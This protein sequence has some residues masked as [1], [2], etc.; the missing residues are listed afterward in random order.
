MAIGSTWWCMSSGIEDSTGTI[1]LEITQFCEVPDPNHAIRITR[2][3]PGRRVSL[4]PRFQGSFI[5]IGASETFEIMVGNL[6]DLGADRY[7]L[8]ANSNAG[9][10]VLFFDAGMTPISSTE[11]L[12]EGESQ[13]VLV[14]VTAPPGSSMGDEDR[15]EITA[16]SVNDPTKARTGIIDAAIPTPFAQTYRNEDEYSVQ[17]QLIWP[18]GQLDVSI[19]QWEFPYE[20]AV[21]ETPQGNFVHVWQSYEK[22]NEERYGYVLKYA[23]VDQFG[24]VITAV[25]Q[26]STLYTG[27]TGFH[28]TDVSGIALAV[29]PDGNVGVTWVRYILRGSD[30]RLNY[31]V[32]FADISPTGK[33][34]HG[35]ERITQNDA[36]SDYSNGYFYF[37]YPR[38]AASEDNH[39]MLA[40]ARSYSKL[41]PAISQG[42]IMTTIRGSSG[43]AVTGVN[44]ITGV[45]N[46]A[47][48]ASL[49]LTALTDNRFFL[50]HKR[51][52]LEN[53]PVSGNWWI[54]GYDPNFLVYNS[55]GA[56]IVAEQ[57]YSY[58]ADIVDSIQTTSGLLI[59]AISD[60]N[61]YISK[62]SVSFT[63]LDGDDYSL[64]YQP[65]PGLFTHP[66]GVEYDSG[67]LSVTQDQDGNAI[68]TWMDVDK[69]NL[70]YALI[71]PDGKLL[72]SPSIFE[73]GNFMTSQTG[74]A[75]T[76]N[77]STPHIGV[78]LMTEFSS[79]AFSAKPGETAAIKFRF[80]N[81]GMS[82]ATGV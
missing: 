48:F 68:M 29:A 6:G 32:W 27:G 18:V 37:F 8:T 62:D 13:T 14:Q 42:S 45:V 16:T 46:N 30:N 76:T 67:S 82:Q 39:F 52:D 23:V 12:A 63:I 56:P 28:Y 25:T 80:A 53:N 24:E 69:K 43:A 55:V 36:F 2:P 58:N 21:V 66:S 9:W 65:Y 50:T 70:F 44:N 11:E 5:G 31:N 34:V 81:L 3:A 64:I 4:S 74:C 72:T 7:D 17:T 78:D 75:S 54:V 41:N 49:S 33:I 22:L 73:T 59:M 10:D 60:W 77:S 57:R 15:I 20:P 71:D 38:I 47:D 51:Y 26:L 61:P 40:W 19:S 79:S 35:P 1:G